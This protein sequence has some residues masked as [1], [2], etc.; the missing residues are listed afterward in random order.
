VDLVDQK[1]SRQPLAGTCGGLGSITR[2]S[3]SSS[4]I[5]LLLFFLFHSKIAG[6]S[7][8]KQAMQ[9]QRTLIENHACVVVRSPNAIRNRFDLR[10]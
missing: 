5:D 10:L 2:A 9:E 8:Q 4:L 7:V 6:S 3:W 1:S